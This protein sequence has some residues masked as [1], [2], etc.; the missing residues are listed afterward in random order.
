[1]KMTNPDRIESIKKNPATLR[2]YSGR[3]K[4]RKLGHDYEGCCPFHSDSKPSFQVFCKEGVWLWQCKSSSCGTGNCIQFLQKLDNISFNN[5][6]QKIEAEI[7][8]TWQN[9]KSQVEASFRD[10]GKPEQKITYSL[11]DYQ[12]YETALT[13]SVP[14][15]EFL[16]SRGITYETARRLHLGFRQDLG[17]AAGEGSVIADKGWIALPCIEGDR[18]VSIEYRSIVEKNYRRQSGMAT[19]LFGTDQID[20]LE[21]IFLTEGKFDSA[22]LCQSGYRTIALPSASA[23]LT[24]AEKDL[25]LS[26][27]EVI[28]AGDTDQAGSEAMQR[29]WADLQERTY[30][31]KWPNGCKDANETLLKECGGDSEKFKALV[32]RLTEEARGTPMADVTSLQSAMLSSTRVKVEDHPDRL[33]FP[34][35]A[36]DRMVNILPGNVLSV[37]ATSTGT[38]KTS[39]VA[40][41]T[42]EAARKGEIVLNYSAELSPEEYS[43]LVAAYLLRKDR[44]T[45]TA[46]DYVAA[47]K[48]MGAAKFYI[49]YNPDFTKYTEVLD[50]MEAAIR[51]LGATIIVIDHLHYIVRNE[52][53]TVKAQE[54][55]YQ[56]IV[57]LARKY[58]LK[59]IVVGQPRKANQQSRGKR[60]FLSDAKG[61]ESFSSDSTATISLHRE[62]VKNFDPANP[63]KEPYDRKTEVHLLKGRSQ[64]SGNAYAELMF[65]GEI[66]R[67]EQVSY[68]QPPAGLAI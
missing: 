48:M 29:I 67:F 26:A 43:N 22:V 47:A 63:P 50:L 31:L 16:K 21:P 20:M 30:L 33:R 17:K 64:G 32:E 40:G 49:G 62:L 27:S 44:N 12:K 35:P 51:R 14:A 68:D 15:L 5:A 11:S 39:F 24:S 9:Q 36:V 57:S 58:R 54:N 65:I 37:F 8:S 23:K 41:I 10:F 46:E 45:I 55:A 19:A 4:L 1:M 18:V 53:D 25:L 56:R 59:A 60:V 28:L 13:K 3:V 38:G 34:W 7:G 6:L 66:A 61:S 42:V 52:S 2:V